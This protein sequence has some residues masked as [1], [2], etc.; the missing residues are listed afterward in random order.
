MQRRTGGLV[1]V[2]QAPQ[3]YTFLSNMG[4]E[5]YSTSPPGVLENM[6]MLHVTPLDKGLAHSRGLINAGYSFALVKV[7]EP[8]PGSVS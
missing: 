2:T 3:G 8:G 7:M 1:Q 6:E 4:C 5:Q